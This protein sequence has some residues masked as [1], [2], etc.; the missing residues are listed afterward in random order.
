M[1]LPLEARVEREPIPLTLRELASGEVFSD[2]LL[3]VRWGKKLLRMLQDADLDSHYDLYLR[4]FPIR[5]LP[6]QKA[7][8]GGRRVAAGP[9]QPMR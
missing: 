3:A 6:H 1:T 4:Q 5:V 8:T 9:R 2:V 7:G